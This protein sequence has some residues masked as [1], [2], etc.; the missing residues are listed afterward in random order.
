MG[1][2]TRTI[3]NEWHG[4]LPSPKAVN[5]VIV[6]LRMF[7]NYCNLSCVSCSPHNSSTKTKELKDSGLESY[8]NIRPSPNSRTQWEKTRKDVLDHL[9]IISEIYLTGGEPLII[10]NHWKFIMED[11][12]DEYAKNI[13]LRY[14]T[15]LTELSY[16]DYHITDIVKKY[17]EV[18]FSVSCDHFG[19]KLAFMRYPLDIEEFE[20]NLLIVYKY[21]ESINCTV[22][23]LNIMDLEE[24]EDYYWDKFD[25]KTQFRNYVKAPQYMSIK[26]LPRKMKN[27]LIEKWSKRESCWF[28]R[29]LKEYGNEKTLERGLEY[30]DKLSKFRGNRCS[31]MNVWWSKLLMEIR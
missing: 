4:N 7:G 6:N 28:V 23:L 16:R 10:P 2:S 15:N 11:V 9:D 30:L 18:K 14:D 8:W 22:Q 21:I 29:E 24:I 5:N 13:K 17:E 1:W 25:L 3:S 20:N 12:P 27:E 31:N 26:H 19:E